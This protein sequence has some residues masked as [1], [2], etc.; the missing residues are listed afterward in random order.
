MINAGHDEI[1]VPKDATFKTTI[2][3]CTHGNVLQYVLV[4]G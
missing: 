2:A 1:N 4:F 3:H